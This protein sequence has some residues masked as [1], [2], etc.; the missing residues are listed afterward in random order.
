[1][2]LK[3]FRENYLVKFRAD[4]QNFV[5]VPRFQRKCPIQF[6]T[7]ITR[8]ITVMQSVGNS[9]CGDVVL[10]SFNKGRVEY[11][12]SDLIYAKQI[13]SDFYLKT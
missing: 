8:N 5:L 13:C 11:S 9:F 7:E 2:G 3:H 6:D 1:M 12:I 4:F 10:D